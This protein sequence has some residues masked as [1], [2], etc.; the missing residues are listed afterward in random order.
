MVWSREQFAA[1]RAEV[2]ALQ[3]P[4]PI[5]VRY[6]P[7]DDRET[8]HVLV[9]YEQ[10]HLLR[11]RREWGSTGSGLY[12]WVEQEMGLHQPGLREVCECF[13]RHQEQNREPCEPAY[14]V[15]LGD[16]G[17]GESVTVE[18]DVSMDGE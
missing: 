12:A 9:G 5:W 6:V 2:E 17:P 8:L 1:F 14:C 13:W 4:R 18:F 15:E 11:F 3:T 16:I 10:E 7:G